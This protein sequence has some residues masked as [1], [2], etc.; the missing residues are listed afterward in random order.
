MGIVDPSVC[1]IPLQKLNRSRPGVAL[2]I[3]K[4]RASPCENTPRIPVRNASSDSPEASYLMLIDG[5]IGD[6][7]EQRAWRNAEIFIDGK[8]FGA[9][10]CVR[11]RRSD[12]ARSPASTALESAGFTLVIELNSLEVGRHELVLCIEGKYA[13][14]TV[15]FEIT[16]GRSNAAVVDSSRFHFDRDAKFRFQFGM[17]GSIRG[18][19]TSRSGA[20]ATELYALFDECDAYPAQLDVAEAGYIRTPSVTPFL[21]CFVTQK[22]ALGTHTLRFAVR[23]GDDSLLHV[24]ERSTIEITPLSI[25]GLHPRLADSLA[26]ASIDWADQPTSAEIA[27]P[28]PRTVSRGTIVGV[29]GWAV[30]I[31]ARWKCAV[32]AR[33]SHGRWICPRPATA[34]CM[35]VSRRGRSSPAET[36]APVISSQN[37]IRSLIAPAPGSKST[38]PD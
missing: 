28:L 7:V 31:A 12:I 2:I 8:T 29:R 38:S 10:T 14:P 18:T 27:S 6:P 35:E 9:A 20:V 37:A 3:R 22:M 30:D 13:L 11:R 32:C 24:S 15:D 36:S 1:P 25:S 17:P 23:A 5:W 4:A 34:E 19:V 16:P 21:A 26:L 33:T